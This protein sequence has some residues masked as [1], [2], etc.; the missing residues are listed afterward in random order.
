MLPV[1]TRHLP[2]SLIRGASLSLTWIKRNASISSKRRST[3]RS[4][5]RKP[6]LP[7]EEDDVGIYDDPEAVAAIEAEQEQDA[8]FDEGAYE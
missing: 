6:T 7:P 8:M 2:A 3:R 5:N 4:A 1:S